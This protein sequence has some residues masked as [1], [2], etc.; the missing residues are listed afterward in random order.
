MTA[1]E[2]AEREAYASGSAQI[3]SHLASTWRDW[4]DGFP[5]SCLIANEA[6]AYGCVG[7]GPLSDLPWAPISRRVLEGGF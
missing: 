5:R 6:A 7:L 1:V 2:V 4:P 3:T